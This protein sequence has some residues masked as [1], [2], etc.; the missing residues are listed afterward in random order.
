VTMS[1]GV[2]GDEHIT[3]METF[4]RPVG[5]FNLGD[6]RQMYDVLN[7]GSIVVVVH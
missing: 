4:Y 2:L 7:A 5:D 1:G 3:R 6:S